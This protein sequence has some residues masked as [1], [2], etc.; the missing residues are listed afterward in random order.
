MKH[1]TPLFLTIVLVGIALVGEVISPNDIPPLILI[2]TLLGFLSFIFF[3]VRVSDEDRKVLSNIFIIGLFIRL[4]LAIMFNAYV[5]ATVFAGD[6]RAYEWVGSRLA[7]YWETGNYCLLPRTYVDK[8]PYTIYNGVIYYILGHA[9]LVPKVINCFVG[10]FIAIYIFFITKHLFSRKAAILAALLTQFFPSLILWSTLNLKEAL[11]IFALVLVIWKIITLQAEFRPLSLVLLLLPIM[12][13]YY[14]RPYVLIFLFLSIIISTLI[15]SER[16]KFFRNLTIIGII[17]LVGIGLLGQLGFKERF[18]QAVVFER[19]DT[20]RAGIT[21]Y[22]G[23][24]FYSD[25]D[26]ST[27]TNALKFLPIGIIYFLF[28]PFPWVIRGFRY[29]LTLP[30]ILL[31]YFLFFKAIGGIH[32]TIRNKFR[33]SAIILIFLVLLTTTY[34]LVLG[35]IGVAYRFRA[36]ALPFFLILAAVGIVERKDGKEIRLP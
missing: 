36:Q 13:I 10:S 16:R 31:W 8:I 20:L 1:S 15:I 12:I 25:V 27:P 32:F 6:D 9:P 18:A 7:K 4:F 5:E 3:K 26:I 24:A 14:L 11:M 34:S 35:N 33:E 17:L 19:I 2:L 22:G 29:I 28:A 21:S 30:E 23:S